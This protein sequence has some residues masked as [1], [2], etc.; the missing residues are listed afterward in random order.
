MF[1]PSITTEIWQWVIGIDAMDNSSAHLVTADGKPNRFA[2]TIGAV[3]LASMRRGKHLRS[4]FVEWR[5][6]TARNDASIV[7]FTTDH[8]LTGLVHLKHPDRPAAEGL[9]GCLHLASAQIAARE[10]ALSRH[11]HNNSTS[12]HMNVPGRHDEIGHCFPP[13]LVVHAQEASSGSTNAKRWIYVLAIRR[14]QA[15]K[16]FRIARIPSCDPIPADLFQVHSVAPST[17]SLTR[18]AL[19][20]LRLTPRQLWLTT[21]CNKP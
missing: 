10:R 2:A 12:R 1:L 3:E 17:M 16:G 19:T 7:V 6:C 18:Q 14:I 11:L 8:D 15:R 5:L 21:G 13:D 9:L 4:Q 20:H